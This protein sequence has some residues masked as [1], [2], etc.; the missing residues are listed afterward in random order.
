MRT[1]SIGPEPLTLGEFKAICPS[2]PTA[3]AEEYFPYLLAALKEFDIVAPERIAAFMGQVCHET[4]NL[5]YW[6]E[7][8]SYCLN[9]D[10]GRL[11]QRLGNT[12]EADGDGC[13]F[14]GRGPP[15]ITGAA[16]YEAAA[17]ALG[18]PLL[19]HPELA[20]QPE[21]GFRVAG[22]FW[23]SRGMGPLADARDFRAITLKWNGGLNGY[24]DRIK[25]WQR[26]QKA[27]GL[28]V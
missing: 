11:A 6:E 23:A 21:H 19:E 12:P 7:L 17:K 8:G 5:R 27:L 2:L 15:Q 10:T 3:R 9:Y 28:H 22:W 20:A 16:N 26:A 24:A 4:G 25:H 14:K 18:L 1:P 13:L